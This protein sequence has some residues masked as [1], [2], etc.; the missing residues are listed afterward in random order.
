MARSS[1]RVEYHALAHATC[2]AQWLLYLLKDLHIEHPT[3]VA[4]FCDSQSAI[5]IAA[6]SVFHEQTKHFEINCHVVRDKL[7]ARVIHLLPI[8]TKLPI[9]DILTKP[10]ALRPF[11]DFHSK[12][13]MK[14]LHSLAC[15]EVL[16]DMNTS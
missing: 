2:E 9:V 5:H 7:H 16:L 10:L 11:A 8:S 1:S 15:K 3:L 4:I 12:L 6:N 14:N 13:N